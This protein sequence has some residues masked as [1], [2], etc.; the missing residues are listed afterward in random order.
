M[1]LGYNVPLEF[2]ITN[3]R[4]KFL[5]KRFNIVIK[6]RG[7]DIALGGVARQSMF[8]AALRG[9]KPRR[10][11]GLI[12]HMGFKANP[13]KFFGSRVKRNTEIF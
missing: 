5:V 13:P 1:G 12:F 6:K 7:R 8:F 4:V 11:S 10:H 2:V 3:S 9:I